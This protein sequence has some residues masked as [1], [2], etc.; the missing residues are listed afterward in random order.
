LQLA[1]AAS[2]PVVNLFPP[3][4]MARVYRHSSGIPRLI[5]TLC[6]NAL[7]TA[8]ARQSPSVT[9]DVID[10]VA[11]DFRLSVSHPPRPGAQEQE[12]NEVWQAVKT[13]LQLHDHLQSVRMQE[14][15]GTIPI[16]PRSQRI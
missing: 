3:D 15:D 8:F 14:D 1:A 6:E 5:N 11:T 7:I 9:P 13:L 12:G 2:S 10:E 4:T 16:T